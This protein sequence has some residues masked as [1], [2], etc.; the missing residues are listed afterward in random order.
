MLEAVESHRATGNQMGNVPAPLP[1]YFPKSHI[2]SD[3][4][5]YRYGQCH[6]LSEND[7]DKR[8][9]G[10]RR[11]DDHNPPPSVSPDCSPRRNPQKMESILSLIES[12]VT[13]ITLTLKSED[14]TAFAKNLI[15]S[16]KE[17]LLPLLKKAD[18]D[19]FMSKE[20]VLKLFDICGTTLWNWE[21]KGYLVPIRP[22]GSRKV[23]YLRSDIDQLLQKRGL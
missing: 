17:E 5:G 8:P 3:N 16:A 9:S 20:D 11:S 23:K 2:L 14:L 1:L 19:D 10:A 12:G 15:E 13:G 21:K 7:T 6:A 18:K 22:Q 4:H